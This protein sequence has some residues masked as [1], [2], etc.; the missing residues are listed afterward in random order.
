MK[1]SRQKKSPPPGPP[2]SPSE[3]FLRRRAPFI[4]LGLA[5]LLLAL[6]WAV[7]F[8]QDDAF[9]SFIYARS[10]ARGEGLTWF[11]TR[12]EGYTNFLW[13]LWIALGI[14]AGAD[15]IVWSYVGGLTAFFFL[16]AATGK[17]ALLLWDDAIPALLT[18]ILLGTNYSVAAYATGGLET[19]LQSALLAWSTLLALRLARAEK[20]RWT[21]AAAL[22]FLLA[23]AAMTRPDSALPGGIIGL[24]ALLGLYRRR[25]PKRTYLA[26]ALPLALIGSG[27]LGWKLHYYGR[28][29]PNSYY[30]KLG[31]GASWNVNGLRFLGRFFYWYLLWPFFGAGALALLRSRPT[32]RPLGLPA[33]LVAAWFAYIIAIGGDFMEFRFMVPIAPYLFLLAAW[34]IYYPLSQAVA[35][36]PLVMAGAAALILATASAYHALAFTGMTED[37]TL[38]SIA[39][40]KTFYDYYPDG[41]WDRIGKRLGQDLAG[42]DAV[43]ATHA[44]GA[45]PYYSG[46][47][48]IDM[49]GLNDAQIAARG[50]ATPSDYV[51]PGHRRHATL[52]DMKERKVNLIIG[53]PTI[54]T[55]SV[56][57]PKLVRDLQIWARNVALAFNREPIGEITVAAMPLDDGK[58]L[59]LWYLTPTD[60]VSA[61]IQRAGWETTRIQVP[62]VR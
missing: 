32:A 21:E 54:M 29:L 48:T 36:R 22:S 12:I 45:I 61:A 20:P 3:A 39:D 50:T 2:P 6:A 55:G 40:L 10:L 15:P 17:M 16:L 41:D 46:L 23:L 38:D 7:R 58:S 43:I 37:K 34:L 18:V 52:A 33:L 31:H 9:I 47:K 42:T 30:A 14:K 35:R 5:A 8:V 24:F 4:F 19:M 60:A 56:T 11:G 59:V 28:L 53:D 27:W 13:V 49:W 51:R 44:V 62:D 1:K 57:D 26:L 25:A